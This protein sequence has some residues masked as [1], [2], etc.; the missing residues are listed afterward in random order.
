MNIFFDTEF[1]DLTQHSQLISIALVSECGK[2]FY[3]VFDDWELDK[4][5]DFVKNEV[6][7]KLNISETSQQANTIVIKGNKKDI[8]TALKIWLNQFENIQMWA[9]VAHYDWVFFCE[10]FGGAL[11]I[12]K[13]IHYMC[14]DLATLLLAKGYDIDKERIELLYEQGSS[15]NISL[16]NALSDAKVGMQLLNKLLKQ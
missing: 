12:P 5:S 10:L 7:T 9:D 16:H 1:T 6:I 15:A 2:S 14:M 4:C 8:V 3:A 11:H 13:Q